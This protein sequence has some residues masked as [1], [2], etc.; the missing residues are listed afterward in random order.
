MFKKQNRFQLI[1][2][3]FLILTL[4]FNG[5]KYKNYFHNDAN[6][7]IIIFDY[8]DTLTK[9]GST[10]YIIKY[11]QDSFQIEPEEIK[12]VLKEFKNLD[13][14]NLENI[15]TFW[16]DYGKSKNREITNEWFLNLKKILEASIEIDP[17]MLKLVFLLKEKGHRV[18]IFSDMDQMRAQIAKKRGYFDHFD[19]VFLGCDL[20]YKKP[21]LRAY[22]FLISVLNR[23]PKDCIF[24]DDKE[25][26]IVAAQKNNIDSIIFISYESLKNDLENRKILY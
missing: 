17:E 5:F 22:D 19:N 10:F 20:K 24:I 4:A 25:K 6:N 16:I 15:K 12:R 18:V 26:N 21:D 11:F 13:K 3:F 8:D 23:D 1:G 7:K 14:N 9:K 2:L